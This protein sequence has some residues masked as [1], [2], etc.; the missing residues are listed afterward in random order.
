M[1]ANLAAVLER[2]AVEGGWTGAVAFHAGG[3]DVTHAEVHEGAARTAGLLAGLGVGRGDRVLLALPDG[4]ELVWAFLGAVRLGAVAVPVNPRLTGDDH[5]HAAADTGARVVVSTA[6][7]AGRFAGR[8]VVAGEDL[9][10]AAAACAPA[11]PA[12]VAAGDPAYAQYTSGTTGS[13]RAAVH[14]HGDPLAYFDAF[15]GPA[16]DL[17]P[18]DAVL[19]VSKLYFAY[20]LGNSLFFPLLAGCRAVLHAAHPVAEDV[21]ALVARH[22]VTVL[23]SVPTFYARLV[24]AG[25]RTA[26][27]SL[28]VAVS[29]G[30]ALTPALATRSRALLGCPVL[31]GLGS[32]EVGQTF[33]SNTLAVQRD[34]TVG[35]ALP[36]YRVRV[37]DPAGADL[38]PGQVGA[39]WVAGPTLPLGYLGR[40]ADPGEWLHTGDLASI[41]P[42]GFVHLRGRAD[43]VELVGGISVSPQEIEAV[44]SRHPA[45]NEVAV[46]GVVGADG[47]SRLQAFVVPAP[48]APPADAF[49][50]ELVALAR[51]ELAPFM[52]PRAVAFVDALPRTPTGKL[53]RFVLR[54]G[55]WAGQPAASAPKA[56]V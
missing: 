10:A 50:A 33:A 41:D 11:P 37:L 17:R 18:T 43:D 2:R 13:P 29:A 15:A 28:R 39:L 19:S 14:A 38:P 26:W 12:D 40:P 56:A 32:T 22:R 8:T 31:D 24:A 3:R 46:A 9:E 47:A 53:R 54:A 16:I 45:V 20:G 34:G 35:R 30:E 42:D 25:E 23:F 52:V 7:L 5:A 1:R 4:I 27:S 55:A 6:E 44:L 49:E 36:P 48:E 51:A 21:A